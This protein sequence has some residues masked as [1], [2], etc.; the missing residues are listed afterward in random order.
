[1]CLLIVIINCNCKPIERNGTIWV[2]SR[3]EKESF[4][5]IS[6]CLVEIL[7]CP[8]AYI[9]QEPHLQGYWGKSNGLDGHKDRTW[10]FCNSMLSSHQ[11][12]LQT[13][14]YLFVDW[15]VYRTMT[16]LAKLI[17]SSDFVSS[18]INVLMIVE[19]SVTVQSR[20]LRPLSWSTDPS[21]VQIFIIPISQ[22]IIN[23]RGS[24]CASDQDVALIFLI[25]YWKKQVRVLERIL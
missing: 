6:D 2:A 21:A 10:V 3:I 13:D 4:A 5:V 19:L 22:P 24:A 9:E 17:A 20:C 16:H 8:T 12:F 11:D 23:S 18:D 1:M 15:E 7:S 25:I 14:S